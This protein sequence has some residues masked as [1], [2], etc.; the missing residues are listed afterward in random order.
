MPKAGSCQVPSC[1]CKRFSEIIAYDIFYEDAEAKKLNGGGFANSVGSVQGSLEKI[2]ESFDPTG[3]RLF[4]FDVDEE[5][6]LREYGDEY[7]WYRAQVNGKE[8]IIAAVRN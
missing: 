3:Y 5:M 7:K 2:I 8:A 6:E 4:D 1:P